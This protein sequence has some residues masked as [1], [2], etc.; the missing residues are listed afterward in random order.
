M[1]PLFNSEHL[2]FTNRTTAAV[3]RN[4]T[5]GTI[6]CTSGVMKLIRAEKNA[7]FRFPVASL[8]QL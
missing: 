8:I 4:R 7:G 1:L 6:M 3:L 2:M 5:T